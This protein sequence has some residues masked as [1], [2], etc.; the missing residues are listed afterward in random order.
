MCSSVWVTT[1]DWIRSLDPKRFSTAAFE[2]T[3]R[4]LCRSLC[5]PALHAA[6]GAEVS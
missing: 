4:S 2:P 5:P 1:A 6:S 3:S